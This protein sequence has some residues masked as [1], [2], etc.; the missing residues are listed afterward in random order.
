MLASVRQLVYFMTLPVRYPG[1]Q[2]TS[3]T[4]A[5]LLG[6]QHS[7]TG[8]SVSKSRYMKLDTDTPNRLGH[9]TNLPWYVSY[10]E[11]CCVTLKCKVSGACRVITR[12]K[13][14]LR[15]RQ[16]SELAGHFTEVLMPCFD[17]L[18]SNSKVLT[19]GQPNCNA[20]Y[21]VEP[22]PLSLLLPS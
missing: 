18:Q 17:R 10:Q 11:T 6:K 9:L 5:E 14:S 2:R 20:M 15:D 16:R 1:P 8:G 22:N 4:A 19:H 13:A 7:L 3:I 12:D 21:C